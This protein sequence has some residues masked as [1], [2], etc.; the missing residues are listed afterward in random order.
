MRTSSAI[1][2]T[3]CLA[4]IA[5]FSASDLPTQL[6]WIDLNA[7]GKADLVRYEP[8]GLA[9]YLVNQG[10]GN[11]ESAPDL[12]AVP[13]GIQ[14]AAATDVNGDE[15]LELIL[16]SHRETVVVSYRNGRPEL[17][18]R[19]ATGGAVEI[20]DVDLDGRQDLVVGDRIHRQ[21]RSGKLVEMTLPDL[22]AHE[23]TTGFW[24]EPFDPRAHEAAPEKDAGADSWLKEVHRDIPA[25]D[26][27]VYLENTSSGH[28]LITENSGTGTALEVRHTGTEGSALSVSGMTDADGDMHVTGSIGVGT[29]ATVG[30]IQ[31]LNSDPNRAAIWVEDDQ[32]GGIMARSKSTS[33]AIWAFN[34]LDGLALDV[35]A[36]NTSV[37]SWELGRLRRMHPCRS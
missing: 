37:E 27:L 18:A 31:V 21:N 10:D 32:Y 6:V 20:R 16:A 15:G 33:P 13:G 8:G 9:D 34:E 14:F 5:A 2:L 25:P 1:L 3:F 30:K 17:L 35:R 4:P 23:S 11:F 36:T 12:M 24:E 22:I 19:I 7:D 28:A 26:G 29:P